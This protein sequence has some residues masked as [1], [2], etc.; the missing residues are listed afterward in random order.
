MCDMQKNIRI[1][2]AVLLLYHRKNTAKS[3]RHRNG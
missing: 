1:E 3:Y 2:L